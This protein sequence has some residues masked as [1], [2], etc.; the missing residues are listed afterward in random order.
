MYENCC[1]LSQIPSGSD[2]DGI[3]IATPTL[4]QITVLRQLAAKPLSA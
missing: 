3:I 4:L 1:F 2:L